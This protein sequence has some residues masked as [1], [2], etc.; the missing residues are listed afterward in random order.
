MEGLARGPMASH[1]TMSRRIGGQRTTSSAWPHGVCT[2]AHG[3]E[4]KGLCPNYFPI[5]GFIT[6]LY[7]FY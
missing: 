1:R 2:Y 7:D 5:M 4:D 3:P 6:L